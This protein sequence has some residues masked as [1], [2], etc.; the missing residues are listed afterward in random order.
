MGTMTITGGPATATDANKQLGKQNE[1]VIF[2]N[3][4]PFTDCK[5]KI[6]T[7]WIDNAK[8]LHVMLIYYLI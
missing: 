4:A 6:N 2:K 8:D 7:A 3:C 1:G 5:S